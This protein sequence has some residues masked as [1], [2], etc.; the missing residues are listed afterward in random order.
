MPTA[1]WERNAQLKVSPNPPSCTT[2][3]GRTTQGNYTQGCEERR[4][5]AGTFPLGHWARTRRRAGWSDPNS[6]TSP[7]FG[8]CWR[9][10]RR[11]HAPV[12][13]TIAEHQHPVSKHPRGIAKPDVD[14]AL[15]I[16]R[17]PPPEIHPREGLPSPA[18]GKVDQG[19][20]TL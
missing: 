11:C 5:P 20:S 14:S 16:Q 7:R 13:A 3:P 9:N 6:E 1:A 10:A 8:Y 12:W 17:F 2:V 15:S 18:G 4:C 19:Q